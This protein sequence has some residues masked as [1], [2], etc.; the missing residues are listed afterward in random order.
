MSAYYPR[1]TSF[2]GHGDQSGE[3]GCGAYVA[4]DRGQ[5]K[6]RQ[7]SAREPRQQRSEQGVRRYER[8]ERIT[9]QTHEPAS[10]SCPGQKLR[11]SGAAGNGVDDPSRTAVIEQA[12]QL[13][14]DAN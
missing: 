2:P 1:G 4:G 14:G 6:F 10:G 9:R 13:I 12:P 8:R 3:P 7:T 5:R 11:V